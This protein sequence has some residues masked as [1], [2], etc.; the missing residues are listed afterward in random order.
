M[1]MKSQVSAQ[2]VIQFATREHSGTP[3]M[4]DMKNYTHLPHTLAA[5]SA[6]TH[7]SSTV[8]MHSSLLQDCLHAHTPPALYACSSDSGPLRGGVS[9]P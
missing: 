1:L 3:R 8:C 4:V 6:R 5:L 7:P 2:D 9:M